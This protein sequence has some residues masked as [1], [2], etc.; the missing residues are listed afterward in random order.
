MRTDIA[1]TPAD[2][3]PTAAK[4][5]APAKDRANPAGRRLVVVSNRVPVG[6][7]RAGGLAVGLRDALQA[8]DSLW[9]GW[10]GKIVKDPSDEITQ[11]QVGTTT[12]AVVDLSK[13][14]YEGYYAGYSNRALWPAF[15]YRLDLSEF[16][17]R[18]FETYRA[19][20]A[21]FARCLTRL[22]RPSDIIWI[23]DYQLLLLASELRVRG[24][25]N[26]IGFFSHIP[27]PAPEIFQAVPHHQ[28]L[29]TGLMGHDLIGFQSERDR[30]NFERFAIEQ[31]RAVFCPDGALFAEGRSAQARSFPIGLNIED[32]AALV[33]HEEVGA[34]SAAEPDTRSD[35]I[36]GVDRM[37]YSK[38]IPQRIDAVSEL[39]D[40]HP[41]LKG[42]AS[43]LQ[44][45]PPSRGEVEAYATLRAEIEA[46]VGHINGAHATVD[47][48]P[49]QFIATLVE[50]PKLANLYRRARVGL[51][52]PLRD[53]MN[54]VAK[55]FLACQDSDDPGVLVLSE[56]AG[57]AEQLTEALIVNP[58]DISAVARAIYD[59]LNM[60]LD[61]RRRRH[62]AL[63]DILTRNDAKAWSGA[64][65]GALESC[66][67][68]G[69]SKVERAS[70]GGAARLAG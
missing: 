32:F 10:S 69:M 65:L 27:F 8:R 38:G 22:L 30:R 58:H 67:G 62:G 15:H 40:T 12:Y 5:S 21:Q 29:F 39:F 57:A 36:I 68:M 31:G 70:G 11:K 24:V 59:A 26:S 64:F 54:L 49:I 19:V 44:I 6:K 16:R 1:V 9:F 60:P 17:D 4:A 14:Q 48:S 42:K 63:L 18:D 2:A 45:T 61:E 47:W 51:V 23:H 52:T 41:E 33:D 53:G 56:F 66:A 13:S 50:R 43:F 35:L 7:A 28:A 46:K 37:D 3:I 20:N 34:P 25:N 55:E